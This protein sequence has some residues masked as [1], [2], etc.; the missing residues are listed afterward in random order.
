MNWNNCLVSVPH[1]RKPY[2]LYKPPGTTTIVPDAAVSISPVKCFVSRQQVWRSWRRSHFWFD[3][4]RDLRCRN[5][6]GFLLLFFLFLFF[7]PCCERFMFVNCYTVFRQLSEYYLQIGDC[8]V[9]VSIILNW[10]EFMYKDYFCQVSCRVNSIESQYSNRISLTR[11]SLCDESKLYAE[12]EIGN[13]AWMIFRPSCMRPVWWARI[14]TL[15]NQR[16]GFTVGLSCSLVLFTWSVGGLHLLCG[17]TVC[18]W[19]LDTQSFAFY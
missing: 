19:T 16:L 10:L 3:V 11:N 5:R 12:K 13:R 14:K 15:G 4:T 1:E 17:S 8:G 2:L 18:C 7:R 6:R 9:L